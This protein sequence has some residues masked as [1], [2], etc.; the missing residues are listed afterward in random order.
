MLP[1]FYV[2]FLHWVSFCEWVTGLAAHKKDEHPRLLV[3]QALPLGCWARKLHTDI[4]QKPR[5][6]RM[7]VATRPAVSFNGSFH[8][9]RV[10]PTITDE[11][12]FKLKI[13]ITWALWN[14]SDF[15]LLHLL[16]KGQPRLTRLILRRLVP[17]SVQL[18]VGFPVIL[19]G[20]QCL[21]LYLVWKSIL[22][23]FI[24]SIVS[25]GTAASGKEAF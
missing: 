13:K 17:W 24:I 12:D 15:D 25:A 5:S 18:L 3:W 11:R 4:T 22:R 7:R 9:S 2:Q 1:W 8:R 10:T 6:K 14:I 23:L 20:I 21:C 16:E 19:S